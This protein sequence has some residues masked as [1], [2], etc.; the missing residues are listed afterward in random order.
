MQVFILFYSILDNYDQEFKGMYRVACGFAMLKS[1]CVK[2]T[3]TLPYNE[4]IHMTSTY[5]TFRNV[6][7]Y[8]PL[9]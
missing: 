5:Y 6:T 4:L 3:Q 8:V 2:I 9:C 1:E 7:A